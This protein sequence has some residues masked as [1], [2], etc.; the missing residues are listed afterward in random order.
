MKTQNN[1][2]APTRTRQKTSFPSRATKW[3]QAEDDALIAIVQDHQKVNWIEVAKRFPGK[4]PQQV[5][6][7]W[8]KVVN[9]DLVKGS[10]TRQEDELIIDFVTRYGT[11]NWTKLAALLPGRIGKQCRERW[12][13]HLDPS[14]NHGAWTEEEDAKLLELHAQFGNQWVKIASMMPGRSDNSIKNRWN[15]TLK[16]ISP[17]QV[18]IVKCQHSTPVTDIQNVI[19]PP[20]TP[21]SVNYDFPKPN[22]DEQ[23]PE[24]SL[25]QMSTGMTPRS[26]EL[27]SPSLMRSPFGAISPLFKNDSLLSP[28]GDSSKGTGLS[29]F[30][31]S[32]SPMFKSQNRDQNSAKEPNLLSIMQSL[33]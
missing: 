14:N 6:E 26:F 30:S 2:L 21:S 28:W 10:W 23:I 5:S 11:K 9:P 29:L 20:Q 17:D 16:K 22:I 19:A 1:A 3:S 4:T 32:F 13:N 27:I 31:P 12:R 8:N 33:N 7:R 24:P 25:D 18:S 15:S